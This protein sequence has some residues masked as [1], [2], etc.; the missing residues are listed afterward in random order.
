MNILYSIIFSP[1]STF[2]PLN[3]FWKID[4]YTERSVS[5]SDTQVSS[6]NTSFLLNDAL[7]VF[8]YVGGCP[9]KRPLEDNVVE[10]IDRIG[11]VIFYAF[12]QAARP[13]EDDSMT[14]AEKEN[15]TST[16][17]RNAIPIYDLYKLFLP[18]LHLM[19]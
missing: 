8:R 1:P 12:I 2:C 11:A 5:I 19:I 14:R 13:I 3:F 7:G 4:R 6:S 18:I 10:F 16:W 15:L 17:I 9:V